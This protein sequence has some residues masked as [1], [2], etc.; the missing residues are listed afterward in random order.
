M[1]SPCP[2]GS[3]RRKKHHEPRRTFLL[4]RSQR[5]DGGTTRFHS[6]RAEL[7][8]DGGA[9]FVVSEGTRHLRHIADLDSEWSAPPSSFV[10][11]MNVIDFVVP[12]CDPKV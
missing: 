1:P 12:A 6:D 7:L 10:V 3:V 9:G 4:I 5:H 11:E 8:A 2:Y